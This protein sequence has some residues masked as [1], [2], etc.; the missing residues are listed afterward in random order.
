MYVCKCVCAVQDV[1]LLHTQVC[2]VNIYLTLTCYLLSLCACLCCTTA[3]AHICHRLAR[4]CVR[5]RSA[6]ATCIISISSDGLDGAVI[7]TKDL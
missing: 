3:H 4:H 2:K 1:L 5:G 6:A 7:L